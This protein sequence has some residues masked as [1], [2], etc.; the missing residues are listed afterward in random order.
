MV[1]LTKIEAFF[2]ENDP[3][4]DP[5]KLYPGTTVLNPRAFVKEHIEILKAAANKSKEEKIILKP[6]YD[7]L[8]TLYNLKNGSTRKD[9]TD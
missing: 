3:G 6:N 5:V 4:T 9:K 1:P 7:R 8:L 2:N